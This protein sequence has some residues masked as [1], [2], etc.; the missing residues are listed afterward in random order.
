VRVKLI[1]W[2]IVLDGVDRYPGWVNKDDAALAAR[3]GARMRERREAL[4]WSQATLAEKIDTSVEFVSMLERGARM[5]SVPTLVAVAHALGLSIDGLVEAKR[6]AVDADPLEAAAR[7][8]PQPLR[9]VITRMLAAVVD[10][11][12]FAHGRRRSAR[13]R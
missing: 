13:S 2:F 6:V 4:G 11:D 3:I 12:D 7:A 8:V 10:V 5:P 1:F 9:P